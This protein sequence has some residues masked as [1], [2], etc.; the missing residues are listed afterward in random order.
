MY[1]YNIIYIYTHTI[2]IYIYT[3][4]YIHNVYI[5][6]YTSTHNISTHNIY[7]YI[8]TCM[9]IYIYICIHISYVCRIPFT[10]SSLTLDDLPLEPCR[11]ATAWRPAERS[12]EPPTRRRSWSSRAP[13]AGRRVITQGIP[14]RFF[15]GKSLENIGKI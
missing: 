12:R 6:I 5:Y 8:Y 10:S 2:Y 13:L 7:I 15:E 14:W 3:Y 1:I 4:I 11:G 9:Y